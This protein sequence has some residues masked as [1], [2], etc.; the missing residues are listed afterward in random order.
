MTALFKS[1]NL[2]ASQP[3]ISDKLLKYQLLSKRE[4]LCNSLAVDVD[5]AGNL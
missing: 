4:L 5:L 1:G 2:I 3:G